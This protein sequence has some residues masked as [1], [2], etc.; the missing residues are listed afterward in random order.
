MQKSAKYIYF[1]FILVILTMMYMAPTMIIV[2]IAMKFGSLKGIGFIFAFFLLLGYIMALTSVF[3]DLREDD[4]DAIRTIS[5]N[6]PYKLENANG[7]PFSV[8][9]QLALFEGYGLD[10]VHERFKDVLAR[11][12]F[13]KSYLSKAQQLALMFT[14]LSSCMPKEMIEDELFIYNEWYQGRV[15]IL[16]AIDDPFKYAYNSD[17]IKFIESDIE[18]DHY[19]FVVNKNKGITT[20]KGTRDDLVE[21]FKLDW[22]MK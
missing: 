5:E 6:P 11:L 7:S 15:L 8:Y 20:Y 22:S 16:L 18:G 10:M 21:Q 1:F 12:A 17:W 3:V 14:Y 19:V 9:Q 13:D 2:W 4:G